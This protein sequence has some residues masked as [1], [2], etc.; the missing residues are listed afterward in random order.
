LPK[1]KSSDK[2]IKS[3]KIMNYKIENDKQEVLQAGLLL[4]RRS[5]DVRPSG[6]DKNGNIVQN[7]HYYPFGLTMGISTGQG[8]QP[9]KYTG[10]ELDMEHGL[11]QYDY[12]ARQYDPA[13]GRFTTMDPLAE[14]YYSISPYAY[15]GNNPIR[16]IDPTGGV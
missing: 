13:I 1:G 11:M 6:A 7:N 8:V 14:K 2:Q 15:C 12:E 9:Y 16:Y 10:K 4:A 5:E 3:K